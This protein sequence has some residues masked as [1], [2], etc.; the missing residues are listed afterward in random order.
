MHRALNCIRLT[1]EVCDYI[2]EKVYKP[3]MYVGILLTIGSYIFFSHKN[4]I[5]WDGWVIG[6]WLINFS[7][8]FV[9]RG[10]LGEIILHTSQISGL[11]LNRLVSLI[12]IVAFLVF[13]FVLFKL[14]QNKRVT[15]WYFYWFT[16]PAFLAFYIFDKAAVGRKEILL[17]AL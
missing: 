2:F 7:G 17:L 8:G 15:F 6:D 5:A 14:L 9:R 11:K 1:A 12:Q 16:F 10:F 13:C 3:I 4:A